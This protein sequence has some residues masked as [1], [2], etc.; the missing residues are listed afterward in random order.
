MSDKISRKLQRLGFIAAG[1]FRIFAFID[2]TVIATLRPSS[3][4]AGMGDGAMRYNNFIQMAFYNGWKEHHGVKFESILGMCIHLY[5]P[6]H[7]DALTPIYVRASKC[8]Y[9]SLPII[10]YVFQCTTSSKGHS[11]RNCCSFF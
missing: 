11:S 1:R 4:P 3:G 8:Y 10:I 7:L 6:N 9:M 2:C 5:G